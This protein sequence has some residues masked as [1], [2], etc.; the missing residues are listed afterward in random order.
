MI[1]DIPFKELEGFRQLGAPIP[2]EVYM[3]F[4]R[5]VGLDTNMWGL[6][7]PH[8]I[9]PHVQVPLEI[10]AQ[11]RATLRGSTP[12]DI[13]EMV[14]H[15]HSTRIA[16]KGALPTT[17]PVHLARPQPVGRYSAADM[18]YIIGRL[19]GGSDYD[20]M[21]DVAKL[22]QFRDLA[23]QMIS[24]ARDVY[25]LPKSGVKRLVDDRGDQLFDMRIGRIDV[26]PRDNPIWMMWN[27][28][29]SYLLNL[30]LEYRDL[31]ARVK[32][33]HRQNSGLPFC[34]YELLG[35]HTNPRRRDIILS[36]L[37]VGPSARSMPKSIR[38][39]DTR[40][41]GIANSW[42]RTWGQ[43]VD[44]VPTPAL[45]GQTKPILNTQYRATGGMEIYESGL[46][47]PKTVGG[48]I[49]ENGQSFYLIPEAKP[50]GKDPN[51]TDPFSGPSFDTRESFVYLPPETVDTLSA[52]L[53]FGPEFQNRAPEET[54]QEFM[55]STRKVI[56]YG[57]FAD[58]EATRQAFALIAS[59]NFAEKVNSRKGK[60]RPSRWEIA[61]TC[62]AITSMLYG[63]REYILIGEAAGLE[64]YFPNWGALADTVNQL[65]DRR[66]MRAQLHEP[67]FE[68]AKAYQL[69]SNGLVNILRVMG[70]RSAN[71]TAKS[72]KSDL[73]VAFGLATL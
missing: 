20:F 48:W 54:F 37:S 42:D 65:I 60:T 6:S 22:S 40:I 2:K 34:D 3:P 64:R 69:N 4:S 29:K 5:L 68:K 36:A 26:L 30:G 35:R 57:T 21:I 1:P 17:F 41:S 45:A 13:M 8:K 59:S 31:I 38:N 18:N 56:R 11:R 72:S 19:L 63:P 49:S 55:R 14:L 62:E 46:I 32:F 10:L 27:M 39:K 7:L 47:T 15:D 73:E 44:A 66:K 67:D 61:V 24:R 12:A 53:E 71:G 50:L 33:G 43:L 25:N 52:P 70:L 23:D 28:Y 16:L 58:A 51:F 9:M